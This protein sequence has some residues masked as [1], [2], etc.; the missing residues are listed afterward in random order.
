MNHVLHV[1]SENMTNVRNFEITW[2]KLMCLEFV[3]VE[4]EH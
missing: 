1:K 2:V 3:L 4:T